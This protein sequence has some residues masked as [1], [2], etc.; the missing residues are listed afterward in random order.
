MTAT[1]IARIMGHVARY[2][3][4]S[5]D[6]ILLGSYRDIPMEDRSA[7]ATQLQLAS[8]LG[9]KLPTWSEAGAFIPSGLN[10]EQCSSI[11]TAA[12]KRQLFVRPEDTVLD[13]TGGLAVDFSEMIREASHGI[14]LEQN[15]HLV[16]ATEYN[17]PRLLPH[18]RY[19]LIHA[20]SLQHLPEILTTSSPS[21]IYVDPAR[22]EG[23][24]TSRRVYAIEDCTP[25][26][27]AL[28]S[29]LSDALTD[30][31]APRLVVKLS[32]MLDIKH[33]L[34]AHPLVREVYIIAVRGEVK[35]LLLSYDFAQGTP[36]ELED[37]PIHTLDLRGEVMHE[38]AS[39]YRDE[40][41]TP[42]RYADDPEA[43]IYEPNAAIM[44]SGLFA[45][46]AERYELSALHPHSHLYTGARL[47]SE[48]PGRAFRLEEVIPFASSS[49]KTLSKRLPRADIS[50]R[51]FPLTPDA[52][53]RKLRVSSSP[54]TVLMGTTLRDGREVLLH[55]T[56][57]I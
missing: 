2:R 19:T 10:L 53:R 22:R 15:A 6:R 28:E 17:L 49:L 16:S 52:L 47:L 27:S 51:N 33:T 3:D 46:L 20:E 41:M 8:L 55:L 7:V 44:K 1:D 14:Y 36:L 12:L 38:F 34:R 42:P 31:Y 5:P 4:V 32:P 48:F 54:T 26:L 13:L 11:P 57:T 40:A 39:T 23:D 29:I 37:I 56:R 35:E 18:Q 45:T 25:S 21:L 30:S 50:C 24:D 9:R 43:Y